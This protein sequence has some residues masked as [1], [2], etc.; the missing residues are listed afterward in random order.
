MVSVCFV[1]VFF[2]R[3]VVDTV[4]VYKKLIVGHQDCCHPLEFVCFQVGFGANWKFSSPYFVVLLQTN[5][6]VWVQ[7]VNLRKNVEKHGAL[8]FN[9]FTSSI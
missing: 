7:I 6:V 5:L 2:T 9:Y 3:L 4:A 8:G 1:F